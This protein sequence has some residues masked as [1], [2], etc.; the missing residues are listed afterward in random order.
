MHGGE[1]Y[2]QVVQPVLPHFAQAA[3]TSQHSLPLAPVPQHFAALPVVWQELKLNARAA[4]ET[5][6]SSLLMMI[7]V[8]VSWTNVLSIRAYDT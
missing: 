1:V 3:G 4:E 8:L 5:M 7:G 6:I 2:L